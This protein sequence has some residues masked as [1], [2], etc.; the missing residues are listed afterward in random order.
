MNQHG[1]QD[2]DVVKTPANLRTI[3]Q[4]RLLATKLA[5]LLDSH[6]EYSIKRVGATDLLHLY[7]GPLLTGSETNKKLDSF[8]TSQSKDS[9]PHPIKGGTQINEYFTYGW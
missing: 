4:E 8:F 6:I 7:V 9:K 3:R 5:E 2:S 1:Y